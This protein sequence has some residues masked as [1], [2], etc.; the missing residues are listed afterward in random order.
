[1]EDAALFENAIAEPEI[2]SVPTST[3]STKE[4]YAF[5]KTK[6]LAAVW[7]EGSAL[8]RMGETGV[9][10]FRAWGR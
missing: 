9:T 3:P 8:Y 10:V 5:L 1:M 4:R 6:R 7:N 2:V